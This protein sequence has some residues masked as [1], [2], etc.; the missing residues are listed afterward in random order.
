M[1]DSP[2][3][4]R[5]REAA[6]LQQRAARSSTGLF[7]LEGPAS[8]DEAAFAALV[9]VAKDALPADRNAPTPAA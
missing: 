4:P 2:R 7:L 3:A 9:Q 5:V 6:R 1:L 8:L